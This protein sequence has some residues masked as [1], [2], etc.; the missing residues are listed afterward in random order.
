MALQAKGDVNGAI[1]A[2]LNALNGQRNDPNLHYNLGLAFLA[3]GQSTEARLAF[4]EYLKLAPDT[5]D[6][7]DRI[8]YVKAKLAE[9]RR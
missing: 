9:H 5:P 1:A 2:Y 7:H 8:E 6:N 4:R 3:K